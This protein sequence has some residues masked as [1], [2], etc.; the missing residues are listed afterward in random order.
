MTVHMFA[1]FISDFGTGEESGHGSSQPPAMAPIPVPTIGTTDPIAAPVAAPEVAPA[2]P[3]AP[4]ATPPTAVPIFWVLL[5]S[6][7]KV[8]VQ[9][10]GHKGF[11]QT[12]LFLLVYLVSES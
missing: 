3:A 1:N 10:L 2:Y 4:P 6:T 5:T 9:Q 12:W 7:T 11:L 8:P